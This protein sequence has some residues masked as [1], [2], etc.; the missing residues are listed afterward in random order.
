MCRRSLTLLLCTVCVTFAHAE[1]ESAYS[2][3]VE[4]TDVGGV[5]LTDRP[6]EQ[7]VELRWVRAPMVFLQ[8]EG[9]IADDPA[10]NRFVKI[11]SP[12]E[13]EAVRSNAGNL[14]VHAEFSPVESGDISCELMLNGEWLAN[15]KDG[16]FLLENLDRGRHRLKVRLKDAE[17][18]ILA[19]SQEVNFQLLRYAIPRDQHSSRQ[20]QK[21]HT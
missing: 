21:Q 8:R 5:R 18:E 17:D 12:V 11:T 1:T 14:M 7:T 3:Y 20:S 10:P 6:E 15:S 9:E 13:D 16:T 19:E 4:R 2:Y